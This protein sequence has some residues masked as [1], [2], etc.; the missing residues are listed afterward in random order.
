[1]ITWNT[2]LR[3]NFYKGESKVVIVIKVVPFFFFKQMY[4]FWNNWIWKIFKFENE[5]K[6]L[7]LAV[8]YLFFYFGEDG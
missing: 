6:I 1:M 8:L 2:V 4:S 3:W 7:K 5:K